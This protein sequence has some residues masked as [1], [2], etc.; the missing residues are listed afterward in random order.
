MMT[1]KTA[2]LEETKSP[3]YQQILQTVRE[4]R[5]IKEVYPAAEDVF[6][7]FKLTPLEN[8]Q[9]VILGQDPYHGPKQAHGLSFS[10]RKGVP[11]PPSLK[12][13][14]SEVKKS[15]PDDFK[16]ESGD[17]S[18]W[19]KQ[20]VLLL[21][22]YLT[23]EGGKPMSHSQIGWETFTDFVVKTV[24]NVIGANCIFLL[25][26]AHARKKASIIRRSKVLS[27]SHPSPYSVNNGF[28]GC[29]HFLKAN[30]YLFEK[31]RPG[32]RWWDL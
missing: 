2:L 3:Y 9:V 31:G 26:G 4:A 24:D 1:W 7:C 12:N 19:A 6:N 8:V 20:G 5:A 22:T 10:V 13:I 27:T 23:V 21:N 28:L 14:H 18:S 25:W 15:Y 16:A 17:L 30:K 32:I 11:V 29:G